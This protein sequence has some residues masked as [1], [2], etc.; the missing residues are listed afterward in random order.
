MMWFTESQ[1]MPAAEEDTIVA[2]EE[3]AVACTP[4]QRKGTRGVY[5]EYDYFTI[6]YF[7]FHP[8]WSA[9]QCQQKI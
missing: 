6:L 4:K 3:E 9:K 5:M 1:H 7:A 8:C 2:R